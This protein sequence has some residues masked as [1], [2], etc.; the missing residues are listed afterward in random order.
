MDVP[1]AH[2]V[3]SQ[4]QTLVRIVVV[5]VV[6]V[7]VAGGGGAAAAAHTVAFVPHRPYHSSGQPRI[8][9]ATDE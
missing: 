8:L 2:L 9:P 3:C 4:G 7:V 5:V 1:R 6:V